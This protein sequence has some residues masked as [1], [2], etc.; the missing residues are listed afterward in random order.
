MNADE[1]L[2]ASFTKTGLQLPDTK[3]VRAEV[4][5][6]AREANFRFAATGE[7]SGFQ[8]ALVRRPT[9]NHG[10]SPVPH[11]STCRSPKTFRHLA[12]AGYEFYVRA[13]GNDGAEGP[14]VRR[15][16]TIR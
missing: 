3:L 16:F 15:A 8:C 4:S 11:Y 5:S 1:T 6:R 13:T 14:A 10:K 9:G 12:H 7:H 2:T